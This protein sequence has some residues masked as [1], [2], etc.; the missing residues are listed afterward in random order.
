VSASVEATAD[1]EKPIA[2]PVV[3]VKETPAPQKK[4]SIPA[5]DFLHKEDQEN[6]GKKLKQ[7]EI[8]EL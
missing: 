4:K 7:G 5:V 1:E 8:I 6:E 3:E 2:K